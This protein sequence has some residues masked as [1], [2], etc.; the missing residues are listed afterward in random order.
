MLEFDGKTISG[1]TAIARWIAE[2]H[3][4]SCWCRIPCCCGY[5]VLTINGD[6]RDS[7][8]PQIVL[9]SQ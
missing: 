3:G 6:E 1:S 4:E 2:D 5:I 9:F 8:W 7:F